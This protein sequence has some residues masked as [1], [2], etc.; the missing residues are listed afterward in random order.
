MSILESDKVDMIG[1]PLTDAG[2]VVLGIADHLPWESG[3]DEQHLLLLQEKINRYLAFI[4]SGEMVVAFPAAVGKKATNS[5]ASEIRAGRDCERVC[6]S[7][8]RGHFRSR[9]WF[10]SKS[11][12][13]GAD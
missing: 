6:C 8:L 9:I 5:A 12:A 11:L 7:C 1:S 4:E 2:I 13:I 10:R 3:E